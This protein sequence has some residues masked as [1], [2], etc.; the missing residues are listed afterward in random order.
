MT[1]SV[2]RLVNESGYPGMKV[3]EFAFDSR[4]TGNANDYLPHNYTRNSVVYT[5]THDNETVM[6]WLN[7]I[8][9]KEYNKVLEYFNLKKG[10]KHTE[11]C[12]AIVRGAVGSVS[13]TCIIPIQDYL[14]YDHNY[15]MN[16]PSTIGKN[17]MFRLT[18]KEMSDEVWKKIKYLTELYGRVR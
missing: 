9:E 6:G 15:R 18:D 16:T 4:D 11:V 8:T 1:D 7:D 3:L 17:W 12:D 13:D 14:H 2:R 10:I 5:G